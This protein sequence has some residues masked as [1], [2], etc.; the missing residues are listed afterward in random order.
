MCVLTLK[1]FIVCFHERN[2]Y[3]LYS[4]IHTIKFKGKPINYRI[5][6]SMNNNIVYRTRND[7]NKF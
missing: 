5:I 2:N 4:V 3:Y 7:K 1:T 6:S